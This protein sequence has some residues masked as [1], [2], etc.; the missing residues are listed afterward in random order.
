MLHSQG[1]AV[2]PATPQRFT[3]TY[4]LADAAAKVQGHYYAA[5]AYLG[6]LPHPNAKRA[7]DRLQ[8][9]AN[10]YRSAHKARHLQVARDLQFIVEDGGHVYFREV[11]A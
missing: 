8:K 11:A 1:G 7:F 6:R 2:A 10:V 3:V 4:F 9:G 5:K